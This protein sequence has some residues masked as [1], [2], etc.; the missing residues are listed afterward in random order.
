M[1]KGFR[2]ACE[3]NDKFGMGVAQGGYASVMHTA[4]Y[5]NSTVAHAQEGIKIFEE[6]EISFGNDIA[7]LELGGGYYL[8]REYEKAIVTGEKA[9]KLAKEVGVPFMVSWCYCFLAF[10]LRATGNLGR[11]RECAEEALRISQES[12][13]KAAEGM[14]RVLLGSMVEEM[15]PAIIEEAERQIRQGISIWEDYK[16]KT[17]EPCRVSSSR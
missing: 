8:C 16:I 12:N 4:G 15:T 3:V 9:L 10:A 5:G 6:A 1:E 14:A 7:W 17:M 2:N 13:G 11:A